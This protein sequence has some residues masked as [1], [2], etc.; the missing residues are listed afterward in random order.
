MDTRTRLV[1]RIIEELP[2]VPISPIAKFY[3]YSG[4][5]DAGQ[6]SWETIGINGERICSCDTMS[7]LLKAKKIGTTRSED[8]KSNGW[9]IGI[10]ED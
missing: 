10:V 5:K 7:A 9:E 3:S 2:E 8:Y 1:R 6:T 4:P